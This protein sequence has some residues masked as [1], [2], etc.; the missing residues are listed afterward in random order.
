MMG[1]ITLSILL[2]TKFFIESHHHLFEIGSPGSKFF[3]IGLIALLIA[4]SNLFI[5][6][7]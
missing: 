7:T 2:K 3:S 4:E 5:S 1:V 6:S